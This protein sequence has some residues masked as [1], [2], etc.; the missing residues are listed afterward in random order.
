MQCWILE[1]GVR[2]LD[3]IE[4]KWLYILVL[5][6]DCGVIGLEFFADV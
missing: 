1:F 4:G 5:G 2:Q 6:R 3:T